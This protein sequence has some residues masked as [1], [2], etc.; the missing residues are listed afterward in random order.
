MMNSKRC[1][2]Q[3]LW[4]TST[5]AES[6]GIKMGG[7]WGENQTRH[8][9]IWNRRT[10]YYSVTFMSSFVPPP[11][12]TNPPTHPPIHT[13]THTHTHT[14]THARISPRDGL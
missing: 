3:Q 12:P 4:P 2:T 6:A 7:L 10:N 9:R 1:R 11:Q 8:L 5:A 13:P 14:H